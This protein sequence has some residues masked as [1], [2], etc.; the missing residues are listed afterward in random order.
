MADNYKVE[1][2]IVWK[3][4]KRLRFNNYGSMVMDRLLIDLY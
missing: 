3:E 4:I 2:S 1:N